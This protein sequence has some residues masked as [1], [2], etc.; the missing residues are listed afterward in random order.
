MDNHYS[1][2]QTIYSIVKEDNDPTS[3][4]C[5]PA[6]IIVRQFLPWDTILSHIMQLHEEGLVRLQQLE[7]ATLVHITQE[8]LLR[9]NS[10]TTQAVTSSIK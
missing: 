5:K 2:L 7:R 1:T 9:A 10:Q 6:Q 8:G 4:P 3:Y